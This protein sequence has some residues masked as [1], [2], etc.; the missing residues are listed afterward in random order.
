MDQET[1]DAVMARVSDG[2]PLRRILR[3]QKIHW[4]A[5]EKRVA[6]GDNA[7]LYARAKETAMDALADQIFDISDDV[8]ADKD[9]IA[10]AR[11]QVDVRKWAMSKLAP[12]KYGTHA[13]LSTAEG[14]KVTISRDDADL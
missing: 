9:A 12:K 13:T 8:Q 1:F 2:E 4:S 7:G 10:K 11:L 14:L 5:F 6:V 3:E